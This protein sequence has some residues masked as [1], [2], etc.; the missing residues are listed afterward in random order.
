[1]TSSRIAQAKLTAS[2]GPLPYSRQ[3][4]SDFGLVDLDFNGNSNSEFQKSLHLT[5]TLLDFFT[6][7]ITRTL[8]LLEFFNTDVSNLGKFKQNTPPY[9]CF[10]A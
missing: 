2:S 9:F 7:D 3:G 5:L 6:T 4:R 10:I 1:M 8:T